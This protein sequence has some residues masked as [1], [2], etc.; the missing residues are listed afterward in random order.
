MAPRDVQLIHG[1]ISSEYVIIQGNGS[2]ALSDV[3]CESHEEA[4][5]RIFEHLAYCVQLYGHSHAVVQAT[6]PDILVMTINH[7][8][9]IPGLEEPWVQKGR[10]TYF[11]TGLRDIWLKRIICR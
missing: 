2:Q 3:S 5:M 7:S 1:G 6:D 4:D 8:V 9:R 10:H 11:V